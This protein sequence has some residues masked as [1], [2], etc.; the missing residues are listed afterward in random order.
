MA[1]SRATTR[2]PSP[3]ESH[4]SSTGSSYYDNPSVNFF[5]TS[6]NLNIWGNKF[7]FLLIRLFQGSVFYRFN[8]FTWCA[9]VGVDEAT[10]LPSNGGGNPNGWLALSVGFGSCLGVE[11][12]KIGSFSATPRSFRCCGDTGPISEPAVFPPNV[13]DMPNGKKWANLRRNTNVC[14]QNNLGH[15]QISEITCLL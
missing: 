14:Q 13:A 5:K 15:W 3:P 4:S 2:P 11:V 9:R 12:P 1:W 6:F 10:K 7:N 8:N